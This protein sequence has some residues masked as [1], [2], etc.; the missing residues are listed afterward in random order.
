MEEISENTNT[1]TNINLK[2]MFH[3]KTKIDKSFYDV[4]IPNINKYKKYYIDEYCLQILLK[5]KQKK[6]RN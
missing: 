1:N 3:D 4:A 2:E 6:F 5:F